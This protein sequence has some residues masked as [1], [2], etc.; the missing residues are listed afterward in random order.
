MAV[1]YFFPANLTH[2]IRTRQT[3]AQKAF[4]L[5]TFFLFAKVCKLSFKEYERSN[6]VPPSGIFFESFL[7]EI[8]LP[9]SHE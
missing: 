6:I 8:P 1:K 7:Y 4:F 9:D 5:L 3:M 2:G